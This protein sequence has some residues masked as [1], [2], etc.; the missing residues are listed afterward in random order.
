MKEKEIIKEIEFMEELEKLKDYMLSMSNED[1]TKY[2]AGIS[3]S[4]GWLTSWL[5]SDRRI[6]ELI[7]GWED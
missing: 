7:K 4:I 1:Y 5:S 6:E 2:G 3:F